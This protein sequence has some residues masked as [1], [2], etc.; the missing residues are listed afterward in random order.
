MHEFD[1]RSM[2]KVVAAF[3][4]WV[5]YWVGHSC[6]LLCCTLLRNLFSPAVS[7]VATRASPE[8]DTARS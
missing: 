2:L 4:A 3:I 5:R 6:R 1:R 8:H 7:V